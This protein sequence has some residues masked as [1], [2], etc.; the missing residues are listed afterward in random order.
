MKEE[1]K[2]RVEEGERAGELTDMLEAVQQ[3]LRD[4]AEAKAKNAVEIRVSSV[5]T[6]VTGRHEIQMEELAS[7]EW[8]GIVASHLYIGFVY[9]I[10]GRNSSVGTFQ[11][12]RS[13]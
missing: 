12:P 5:Q 1:K 10:D 13:S 2:L 7:F 11:R 9:S 3:W 4:E 8:H 6:E